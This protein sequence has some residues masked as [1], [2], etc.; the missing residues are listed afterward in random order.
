M[1]DRWVTEIKTELK[2]AIFSSN[3][4]AE[5]A[6]LN[7]FIKNSLIGKEFGYSPGDKVQAMQ[8]FCFHFGLTMDAAKLAIGEDESI[9]L[10]DDQ[11]D[12]ILSNIDKH[13]E[14]ATEDT[15]E[16]FINDSFIDIYNSIEMAR[17]GTTKIL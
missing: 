4:L 17:S 11:K 16:I 15:K 6:A 2:P 10:T 7:N 14:E 5:R 8:V 12:L 13:R 1:E 9:P 3:P